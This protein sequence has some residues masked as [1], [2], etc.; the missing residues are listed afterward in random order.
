[1]QRLPHAAV[2][3]RAA[4]ELASVDVGRLDAASPDGSLTRAILAA[5]E[6]PLRQ[7]HALWWHEGLGEGLRALGRESFAEM[8]S[9]RVQSATR[10]VLAWPRYG[11]EG[12]VDE[13]LSR[14]GPRLADQAVRL[15]L[16]HDPEIDG[17]AAEA[18][19]LIEQSYQRHFSEGARLDVEILGR[20]ASEEELA[21]LRESIDAVIEL[22][23]SHKGVRRS[24]LEAIP[25]PRLA[26]AGHAWQRPIS[27][28]P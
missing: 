1:V 7:L 24:L 17:D 11:L 22:P 3:R 2:W 4:A 19:A 21:A 5:L 26:A 10:A 28:A 20:P 18:I 27:Q 9:R 12:E 25:A 14:Y 15:L 16:V 13:L 8:T 23:G 6:A